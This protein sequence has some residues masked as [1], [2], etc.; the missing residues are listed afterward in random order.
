M[1]INEQTSTYHVFDNLWRWGGLAVA[2]FVLFL[3]LTFC[4]GAGVLTALITCAIVFA[5]GFFVV[6]KPTSVETH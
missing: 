3:V 1:P 4:T 5:I 6:K 2:D